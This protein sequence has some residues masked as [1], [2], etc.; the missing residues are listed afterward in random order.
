MMDHAPKFEHP[1][2]HHA[3]DFYSRDPRRPLGVS[4][5]DEEGPQ[6]PW[7]GQATPTR[8]RQSFGW[9][10]ELL[11]LVVSAAAL[12]AVAVVL[13]HYDTKRLDSWT[14]AVSPSSLIAILS[15]VFRLGLMYGIAECL[16]QGKWDWF[17]RRIDNLPAF[18]T[19]DRASRGVFGSLKLLWWSKFW[20]LP[21]LPDLPIMR[22]VAVG[23]VC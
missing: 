22:S 14:L 2:P 12:A 11:A 20:Y 9:G 3:Q 6:G 18:A 1:A 7:A 15:V 8:P 13:N 5:A 16:G 4:P 10:R 19:I 17:R 21:N 23:K